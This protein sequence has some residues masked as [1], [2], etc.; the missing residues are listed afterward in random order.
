MIDI[1]DLLGK[2]NILSKQVLLIR[3]LDDASLNI[4]L[5][6]LQ[7]AA[8]IS[9]DDGNGVPTKYEGAVF[10]LVFESNISC[11]CQDYW[12]AEMLISDFGGGENAKLD[13]SDRIKI[14]VSGYSGKLVKEGILRLLGLELKVVDGKTSC[15]LQDLQE[16]LIKPKVSLETPQS[17]IVLGH[18]SLC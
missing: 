3:K 13:D 8:G 1:V 12:R 9:V 16:G 15:T 18:L 14:S 2:E 10:N 17:G 5:T 6:A 4:N 7:K 11:G